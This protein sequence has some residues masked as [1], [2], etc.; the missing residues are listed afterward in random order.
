MK[1]REDFEYLSGLV[2]DKMITL[3][4][5]KRNGCVAVISGFHMNRCLKTQNLKILG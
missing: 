4:E 2:Q 1:L 3:T 5:T